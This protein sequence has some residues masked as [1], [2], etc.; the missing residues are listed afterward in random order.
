MSMDTEELPRRAAIYASL[1][2]SMVTSVIEELSPKDQRTKL[3]CKKLA[4]IVYK[5][6]RFQQ[7]LQDSQQPPIC[8]CYGG[9]HYSR[10]SVFN[11]KSWVRWG[12]HLSRVLMS[13]VLNPR[14]CRTGFRP[15]G[16]QIGWRVRQWPPSRSPRRATRQAQK[17]LPQPRRSELGLQCLSVWSRLRL[18]LSS[19]SLHGCVQFGLGSPVRLM[20]DTG[21]VV[22][23]SKIVAHQ[24]SGDAGRHQCCERLPSSSE[25]PSGALDVQQCSDSGLHQERGRHAILYTH[26]NDV[27]PAEV[28]RS[29]GDNFSSRP[30]TRSPQH[31]GRFPVQSRPDTEHGVD[32]G[33][34][35]SQ[36]SICPVGWTTGQLVCN[37]RQQMIHQVCIALSR[38]QG[39]VH[40]HHV[41]ALGPRE[42]PPVCVSAI[43]D[44]P[45]SSAE[46]RS[47][48]RCSVDSDRSSA[49]NSFMV[50]GTAWTFPRR[51]HPA[52]R[53][54]SADGVTETRHYRPS[55]LQG[56]RL[57]GPS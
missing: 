51:S 35:A 22:S 42:G 5:K 37:I 38:P 30:S 8:S 39:W 9:T 11:L 52:V 20:L 26:A 49:G 13:W 54:G 24:R 55:N 48:S 47:V 32:D 28:V 19:D 3:L 31:P 27:A 46:G 2:D 18:R 43:Q 56:W 21:T 53:R 12:R 23:I 16:R 41:S 29:Q 44:G 50:P 45:S 25:V 10:T 34:G 33:H 14:F 36:T 1:A 57:C 40:G 15:S 4:I 17:R 6:P 7:Y